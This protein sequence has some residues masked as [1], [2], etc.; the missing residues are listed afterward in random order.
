MEVVALPLLSVMIWFHS[1]CWQ[2]VMAVGILKPQNTGICAALGSSGLE[3]TAV[4]TVAGQFRFELQQ[5]SCL[6]SS[7]WTVQVLLQCVL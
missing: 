6:K 4:S 1:I 7:D 2:A 3:P 5:L